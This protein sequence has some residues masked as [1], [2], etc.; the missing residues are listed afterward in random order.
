MTVQRI[1]VNQSGVENKRWKR[2]QCV[3]LLIGSAAPLTMIPI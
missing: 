1:K 3:P 2:D